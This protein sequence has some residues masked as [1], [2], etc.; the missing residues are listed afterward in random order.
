MKKARVLVLI[1]FLIAIIPANANSW[2]ESRTRQSWVDS[3]MQQLTLR[4]RIAQLFMVAV[5]PDAENA[6][7]QK[8]E[9][10]VAKEQ[11]GGIIIMRGSAIPAANMIN[12]LQKKSN[13]PLL[14]SIDGEY[15]LAMRLDSVSP[16][17]RQ[18][19]LG[20]LS[21]NDYIYEMGKAVA[22]QC[23]RMGIYMNFAPVADINNNPENPVINI[24][25]FGEDKNKVAEKCVAYMR[26]MQDGGIL[27][28]AKHFPGHG[29]T[30][31]DSHEVI[32]VL[33]YDQHRIDTLELYPFKALMEAGIDAMMVGHLRIPV[34]DSSATPASLSRFVTAGLLREQLEYSGLIFTDALN[35]KGVLNT[36]FKGLVCLQALQAGNDILLMPDDVTASID[37][38]EQAVKTGQLSE[39]L[40]NM[41]CRKM[42]AAKFKVG[43]IRSTPVETGNLLTDLNAGDNE[44]LR[45][46][47]AE[48]SITLLSNK[49]N[50]LPLKR[51]DS[52]RIAYLELGKGKGGAFKDQLAYYAGVDNFAMETIASQQE[53]DSLRQELQNYNL[54]I[55][56]FHNTDVRPASRFGVDSL[57]SDFLQQLAKQK[58][59][60]LNFFGVPYGITKFEGT[61]NYAAIIISYQNIPSTQQRSAQ[62][63]FG[64]IAPSGHLPVYAGEAF[65]TGSGITWK[66]TVRLKYVLPEEIGIPSSKLSSIDSLVQEAIDKHATPGAQ[67]MAIHKG[68]V[69]YHKCFGNYTYDPVSPVVL[70]ND[71]YDLASLTKVTATLSLVM[72]LVGN[73]QININ[74]TLGTYLS[75]LP[76]D[77][78][79]LRLDDILAHRSGL[80]AFL[81]FQKSFI[82][83]GV[84]DT[85]YISADTAASFVIQVADK[86]YA[87]SEVPKFIY[88][89]INTTAL[90]S[91]VYRYSDWGFMYMQ[92]V[93]EAVQRKPVD[94]LADSLFYAPLGMNNT[95]YQP[96]RRI[97]KQ[98]IV[99]TEDDRDFRGQLLQGY[100][101]DPTTSLLGGV[102]GHAGLFGNANDLAKI[103]QMYLNRGTYGGERYLDSTVV[104]A[105]TAC[106]FC[107]QGVRRGLGFDK[108]EPDPQKTSPVG[109]DASLSSYGHSGYTGTFFWVDPEREL[110]YIFLSNRVYPND[111]KKINSLHTRTRIL[112]ILSEIIDAL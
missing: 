31:K 99:P 1:I 75:S 14:T 28:C 81:P 79:A 96:L 59:V 47:I 49:D 8:V 7:F 16:F 67:V 82:K 25:S 109:R 27:T 111:D 110:V 100:V 63:I 85:S 54:L 60:I 24:R 2:A 70:W 80:P 68:R 41:K 61:A 13:I 106:P 92:Q 30:D 53:M 74:K 93:V 17:P 3:L 102:A 89:Q 15:G 4:Q 77:R 56:G 104:D 32:P 112:S 103:L 10:L 65:P 6:R 84:L 42:L 69:F 35:M 88:K 66:K 39:Y 23:R 73:K 107:D 95:G 38:I 22:T 55:V 62:L 51:L 5:V 29:D 33:H 12:R 91:K 37:M 83:N 90:M 76:K 44:A 20:A 40:I 18:M 108:P 43:L 52:L 97:D 98:R 21:D 87:S 50:I 72:R 57:T 86:L 34:I 45:L 64:G 36:P 105:F 94:L 101:H 11:P 46:R 9:Q 48:S 78:K 58:K 26:G 71:V 19:Q